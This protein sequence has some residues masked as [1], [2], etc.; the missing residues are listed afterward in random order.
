M[1]LL[2]EH[3]DRDSD[4]AYQFLPLTGTACATGKVRVAPT[5]TCANAT[6][7]EIDA[8]TYMGE[9]GFNRFN[10]DSTLVSLLGSHNFNKRLSIEGVARHKDGKADYHQS[11]LDFAGAGNPRTNAAGDAGRTFYSS[12]ADSEQLALDLRARLDFDTGKLN[13]WCC[14]APIHLAPA[15]PRS[16]RA[17][18]STPK[19]RLAPGRITLG[20]PCC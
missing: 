1:T 8:A 16:V 11:W 7:V 5:S 3:A 20:Q 9:P 18:S 17:G 15:L 2:Y 6:G 10:T 13:T 14:R 4:T 19:A 12:A